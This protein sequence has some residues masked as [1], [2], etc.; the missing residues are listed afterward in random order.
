MEAILSRLT[1]FA[2]GEFKACGLL[3]PLFPSEGRVH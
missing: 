3:N 2:P 1:S